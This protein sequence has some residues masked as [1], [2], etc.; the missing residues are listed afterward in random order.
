MV[1]MSSYISNFLTQHDEAYLRSLD[2]IKTVTMDKQ[3]IYAD[4]WSIWIVMKSIL[5]RLESKSHLENA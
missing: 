1:A 2:F 5:L 4:V 3:S